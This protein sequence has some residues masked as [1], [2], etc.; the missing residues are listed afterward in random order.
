M[1]KKFDIDIFEVLKRADKKEYEYFKNLTDKE[2]DA[3]QPWVA[4]RFMSASPDGFSAIQSILMT[5]YLLNR[6]F[7]IISKDKE[8]FYRL[9]CVTGDGTF[10]KRHMPKPPKTKRLSPFITDLVSQINGETLDD[11]EVYIYLT[12]NDIQVSDLKELAEDLGYDKDKIKDLKKTYDKFMA[13][14]AN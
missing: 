11:E 10:K 7:K 6:Q 1:T 3:F 5:N 4:M 14:Y 13:L 12:K 9:M 2:K 8:L